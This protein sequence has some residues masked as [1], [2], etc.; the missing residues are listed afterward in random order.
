MASKA[1]KTRLPLSNISKHKNPR[2]IY[3]KKLMNEG[4]LESSVIKDLDNDFQ[5]LLQDRFDEAKEIKKAKITR[6]LKEEWSGITRNFDPSFCGSTETNIE[7]KRLKELA[8]Y[9]YEIPVEYKLFKKIRKLLADR[10]DMFENLESLNWAMG[11]LLA[12]AT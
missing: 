10:K 7:V 11:E 2:E 5:V 1:P 4:V 9:L 8:K 3:I 12:Y 6:F